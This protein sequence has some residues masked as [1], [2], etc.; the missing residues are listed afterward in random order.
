MLSL[1]RR[2]RTDEKEGGEKKGND[3][4]KE[5]RKEKSE[6]EREKEK[7]NKK[8]NREAGVVRTKK[9]RICPAFFL[10]TA[11]IC[12]FFLFCFV[13]NPVLRSHHLLTL[14]YQ[15]SKVLS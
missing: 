8:E 5:L 6:R 2:T 14:R 12:V 10:F 3:K 15:A 1:L 7:Q 9:K 4:R 13:S 11:L